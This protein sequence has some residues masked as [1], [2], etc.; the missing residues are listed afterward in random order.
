MT[1]EALGGEYFNYGTYNIVFRSL[2]GT[3]ADRKDM[4]LTVRGAI[5]GLSG[6]I[7][8]L[9]RNQFHLFVSPQNNTHGHKRCYYMDLS[10]TQDD[11]Y[12]KSASWIVRPALSG[13]PGW[14]SLQ[15]VQHPNMYL[16][17]YPQGGRWGLVMGSPRLADNFVYNMLTC[18]RAHKI[19]T[20]GT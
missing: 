4:E 11:V 13:E 2:T 3:N 7:S 1:E 9:Y 19:S 15:N 12:K 16:A 14:F 8:I 10:Q 17:V 6:A 20:T 5:S 18:W